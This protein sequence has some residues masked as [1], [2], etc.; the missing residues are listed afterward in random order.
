MHFPRHGS[1]AMGSLGA[2]LALL[3][4]SGKISTSGAPEEKMQDSGAVNVKVPDEEAPPKGRELSP[5]QLNLPQEEVEA[6]GAMGSQGLGEVLG[7]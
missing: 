1:E 5:S 7:E 6:G 2:V 3:V 4:V